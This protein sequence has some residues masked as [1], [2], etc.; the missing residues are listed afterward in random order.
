MKYIFFLIHLLLSYGL[1]AQDHDDYVNE[2]R[3]R[4]EDYVYKSNIKTVLFHE[5]SWEFAPPVL[6]LHG[7]EKLLLSFDDLD[8]DQ[9][10]YTLTFQHCNAD[11]TPS[12]L[13]VSEYLNGFYDLNIL[14][15]VFASGTM[16]KYTHY[17]ITFP[18]A[19]TQNNTQFLKSGNYLLIVY[20]N[21][22]REDLVLCRR[23]MVYDNQVNVSGVVRQAVGI[24]QFNKQ[25]I[26]FT[27]TPINN[28][29]NNPIRDVKVVIQQ[30]NRWDNI[31]TGMKP[32]FLAGNQ[33]IYSID[34]MATFN[35]GN[36]FRFFDV[37]SVRNLSERVKEIYR[38]ENLMNHA[39][40]TAD[41]LRNRKPYLFYNDFNGNFLI[42]SYQAN[43]N[44]D[45]EADYVYVDFTLNMPK[46]DEGATYYIFGK[47][48]DW[49]LNPE[50]R[51]KYNEL[52]L[53]YEARVYLKQGYYNYVF[54][55]ADGNAPEGQELSAEGSFWD[56][57]NDYMILVYYRK[58]GTYYDQLVGCRK[59]NTLRR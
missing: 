37:R 22:N 5:V 7:N 18:Q 27:I 11:W 29:I 33:F 6:S 13:M 9:K 4:Y 1:L 38:D 48:S 35:G 40:L 15:S 51:M 56:T 14:N 39:V 52:T 34:D 36:E 24:D 41:E 50:F 59:M 2:Q 55:R 20:A 10:Q 42:K 12:D 30:N 8:G 53:K 47:L 45:V 49:R 44:S 3:I 32:T 19:N 16:Q 54:V 17:D 43:N 25:H 28:E 26:D 31:S 46:R 57:E 58:I 21:G 23:F